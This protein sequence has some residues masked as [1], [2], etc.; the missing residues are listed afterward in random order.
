M[1]TLGYLGPEG[2]FSYV[3]CQALRG[4]DDTLDPVSYLSLP[5][6]FAAFGNQE[7]DECLFP[8]ENSIEGP[9]TSSMDALTILERGSIVQEVNLPVSHV[10]MGY[11]QDIHT[12]YSHPQ[13]LGQCRHYLD[14][15][16]PNAQLIDTVSTAQAAQ[17]VREKGPGSAAIGHYSLAK[18][19]GL[20][21][22][23][24]D[25][26]DSELNV[27][28]F[29]RLAD[30]FAAPTGADKTSIVFATRK[31]I[32][33]SLCDVLSLFSNYD[34]NLSKITSRP[35][36]TSLGEY[37]FYVDCDGYYLENPLMDVL[38]KVQEKTSFYKWLG[39]YPEGVMLD[40]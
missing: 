30:R 21:V 36:K 18:L 15:H 7:I 6:L 14:I 27:T 22:L 29:L 32:P 35:V 33:G 23:A 17:L 19:K 31:D 24:E 5:A 11:S 13:P 34:I 20:T 39:S 2:T 10:L 16:F 8:I 9:V 40:A 1:T 12:I 4:Q 37:F 26:N 38:A 28:R 3:A 25:I